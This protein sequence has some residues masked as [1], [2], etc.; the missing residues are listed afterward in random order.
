MPGVGQVTGVMVLSVWL[1]ALLGLAFWAIDPA[2][3][4]FG[5]RT[6]RRSKLATQM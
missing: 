2:L 1:V 6:F 3:L 4:W 5:R